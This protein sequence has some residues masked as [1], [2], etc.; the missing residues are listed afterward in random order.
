MLE[1]EVLP[2]DDAIIRLRIAYNPFE[3]FDAEEHE[4]VWRPDATLADYLDG[5]PTECEWL[6]V[7]DNQEVEPDAY[8]L[9]KPEPGQTLALYLIPQGGGGGMKSVFRIVLQAAAIAL[10]FTGLPTWAIVAINIGV[11]LVNSFLLAP[12]M[13]K[14]GSEDKEDRSYGIDGAKNSATEGIPVPVGYGEF[15][16]AG[17]FS[18]LF[19]INSG[20]DQYLYVRSIINDGEIDSVSDFEIDEQPISN[21]TDV[22]TRVTKGTLTEQVNDWFS[23]TVRQVNRSAKIDT[24]WLEHNTTA[25]VDKMRFDLAFTEGLVQIKEKNGDYLQHSVTFQTEY[26]AR[27]SS[28][29]LPLPIAN[30]NPIPV[31][32]NTQMTVNSTT[33]VRLVVGIDKLAAKLLGEGTIA[34]FAEYRE[35]GSSTWLPMGSRPLVEEDFRSMAFGGA[36]GNFALALMIRQEYEISLPQGNYEVRMQHGRILQLYTQAAGSNIFTITDSRTRQIRKSYTSST[37][38]KG[39]YD[40]RIRRTTATSTDK[41]FLDEVFLTDFGEIEVDQVALR[42]KATMSLKVKLS[43]QLNRIPTFTAKARLSILQ[44]YDDT[45]APTIRRWSGNPAWVTLDM[46]VGPERGVGVDPARID[47]PRFVEWA[48]F[49]DANN[50]KFNGIFDR[51]TN[52]AEALMTVMRVGRANPVRLG[53]KFSLAIDRPAQPD[54]L[55]GSSSIIKGSLKIDYMPLADRANEYEIT[56]FDREDRNK[57]RTI[58][59][60][61]PNSVTFADTPRAVSMSLVGVDNFDQAN[62]E[63]WRLIYANRLL[64]RSVTAD[65]PMEAINLSIGDIALLQHEMMEWA[66]DGRLKEGSTTT[67]LRLDR[68]VEVTPGKTYSALVHY[69]AV[70]RAAVTVQSV[71]G[72]RVMVAGPAGLHTMKTKRLQVGTQ[73]LEIAS[74]RAGSP[75]YTI[76]LQQV[77]G[78]ITIG[79]TATIWDTDVVEE[80]PVSSTSLDT[81]GER[82][83]V[84]LASALPSAPQALSTFVF[85]EIT[86]VKKPYRLRAISGDGIE[87]RTLSLVEYHE[88]V[89][90]EPEI[91]IPIPTGSVSEKYVAHVQ[92][93]SVDFARTIEATRVLVNVRIGW[94]ANHVV[95]YA[96]ADVYMALNGGEFRAVSSVQN[97]TECHVVLQAADVAEFKVVAFNRNGNRATFKTAPTISTE[98][99]VAYDQ[100]DPPTNLTAVVSYFQVDAT[101]TVDWDEPA[102]PT[103]IFAYEVQWR[104]S[105]SGA[106]KVLG[107]FEEGPARIM[108][109]DLGTVE[110]RVRSVGGFSASPWVNASVDILAPSLRNRVTGLRLNGGP[111][112]PGAGEFDGPDAHFTW[113]DDQRNDLYFLDYEIRIK[114]LDDEL[115]R[116]EHTVDP[117]YS[118]TFDKNRQDSVGSGVT[119]RRS[120][121]IEVRER[122]R[123]GQ[124]NLPAQMTATNPQPAAP[125]AV[126]EKSFNYV[127]VQ[128][129]RP[130]DADYAGIRVWMDT[131]SPVALTPANLK[132]D[133]SDGSVMINAASNTLYYVRYAA[134]D[135]FGDGLGTLTEASVLTD[136]NPA[137]GADVEPPDMPTNLTVTSELTTTEDDVEYAS[138]I[139]RFSSSLAEDLSGYELAVREE[140]GNWIIVAIPEPEDGPFVETAIDD[141]NKN[142]LH[143]VK[144]RAVDVYG[145]RSAWTEEVTH[146][147]IADTTPP[148]APV[149]EPGA[150]TASFRGAWLKWTN[151]ADPDLSHV[152][153]WEH[154]TDLALGDVNSTATQFASV[155]ASSYARSGLTSGATWHYWIRSVDTSG[156]KSVFVKVGSA[157]TVKTETADYQDLSIVNAAIA[158]AAIDDAKVLNLSAAK[159]T[160]GTALAG[161][162]TVGALGD[163]LATIAFRAD[164]PATRVNQAATQ[165]DPGKILISGATS[166]SDWRHGSDLTKIDGGDIYANSVNAN[167]VTVGLRGLTISGLQF[168]AGVAD[169]NL[170]TWSG[171]TIQ[172][173]GDDGNIATRTIS[174]NS[175]GTLWTSGTMYVYWVKGATTLSTTNDVA[176]A[177]GPNN[178]ILATYLGGVNM[179]VTYGRTIIDGNHISTGTIDVNRLKSNT[180]IT[181]DLFIGSTNFAI[182][183]SYA[184]PGKGALRVTNGSVDLIKMGWING[185]TLGFEIRN[186]AGELL[187]S[188]TTDPNDIGGGA[189]TWDEL[190]GDGKPINY[191]VRA[192]GYDSGSTQPP[193]FARGLRNMDAGT[194]VAGTLAG[195]W[196]VC[197]LNSSNVWEVNTYTTYSGAAQVTAMATRLTT[198]WS[199]AAYRGRPIVIYTHDEPS[200]NVL[201]NATWVTYMCVHGATRAVLERP[202][203]NRCAYILVSHCGAGA[204]TGVGGHGGGAVAEVYKGMEPNDVRAWG[205]VNFQIAHGKIV[206]AAQPDMMITDGN[207]GALVRPGVVGETYIA[208]LA[209]SNAKIANLAVSEGKIAN[210]AVT[211]GK[212]ANLAVDNAKIANVAAGKITAGNVT[213][214]MGLGSTGKIVLDGAN[215]RILITD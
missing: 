74:I 66:K 82:T 76:T 87:K 47:W 189:S 146:T 132:H 119:A 145:N 166:L 61:D 136:M 99:D 22:E 115:L 121:K 112:D 103:G 135:M 207:I 57:A 52:L 64:I 54:M 98:I 127:R 71:I 206:G 28:T 39:N 182:N 24:D 50:L 41:Y 186:A 129:T 3:P 77:P 142:T 172:Y 202:L 16:V 69:S 102:D 191:R 203:L 169:S 209:V 198:L 124:I 1:Q 164:D 70:Q 155:F 75:Y 55:L 89:Y 214:A 101:V 157:T 108:Q 19:T 49:C 150:V 17:N 56:Y 156:N 81:D 10:A 152:E 188:S 134:Y 20:D 42:G 84:T 113:T 111:A 97:M 95:N 62:E 73:D 105:G 26:K 126:I 90:A 118:Y 18:D 48:E 36:W 45:G 125:A 44:E 179:I 162:I 187:L 197:V 83:I 60:V 4:L 139:V 100:L 109:L 88:G 144:V 143:Y 130:S 38:P 93:L 33:G 11:G 177:H 104:M 122:G 210:L 211:N 159:L 151:P 8:A 123:Q 154:P 200:S 25:P 30:W 31:T 128:F 161:S 205:E 215:N 171:G 193:G 53:T 9:T 195:N 32:N 204:G 147:T 29:W 107:Q 63:L 176:V 137:A 94:Q 40:F 37:L 148:A 114:S 2:A 149:V 92:A 131:T 116:T 80:R 158:D 96:G 163:T 181:Q 117:A 43:D 51:G 13:P 59:Y 133:G 35:V 165:I 5:L 167:T 170:I 34:L 23:Q 91:E 175:T 185:S 180:T 21:F 153:L 212:I 190:T 194:D 192:T 120:F 72:K 208:N 78:A 15:R 168:Q 213:V 196:T 65:A 79:T 67:V 106:W 178:V 14:M 85:G 141:V 58:R 12:R 27:G 184:G 46:L 86:Q 138:L 6:V 183:G 160:A 199:T 201:A 174:A 110:V 7:C 68:P 173:V 140:T